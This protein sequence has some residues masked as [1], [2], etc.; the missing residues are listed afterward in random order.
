M[1]QGKTATIYEVLFQRGSKVRR[2]DRLLRPD[3]VEDCL[4]VFNQFSGANGV[5]A[6]AKPVTVN[7][8]CLEGDFDGEW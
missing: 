7:L 6:I 2:W 3:E 4:A 5:V 1:L 8:P